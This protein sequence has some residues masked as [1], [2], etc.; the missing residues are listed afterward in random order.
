[1]RVVSSNSTAKP[2]FFSR[3]PLEVRLCALGFLTPHE[4]D[5]LQLVGSELGTIVKA[6]RRSSLPLHGV[7]I[8]KG[9][10]SVFIPPLTMVSRPPDD[11]RSVRFVGSTCYIL[12]DSEA[13]AIHLDSSRV[14]CVRRLNI[15]GDV[16]DGAERL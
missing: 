12:E 1:M 9:R 5:A 10:H 2:S 16:P 13:I 6:H 14:G 3:A 8:G 7:Y 11:L 15:C 4:I